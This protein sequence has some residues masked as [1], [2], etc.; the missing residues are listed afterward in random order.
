MNPSLLGRLEDGIRRSRDELGITFLVI[1]HDMG[2]ISRLC[3]PCDRDGPGIGADPGPTPPAVQRDQRV[4]D[5][6]L[7]G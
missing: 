4:I 7:G 5:A 3:G 1:E 2:L 6:Y